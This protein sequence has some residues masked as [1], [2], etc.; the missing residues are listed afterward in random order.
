[1]SNTK[2]IST[3]LLGGLAVFGVIKGVS[4]YNRVKTAVD[5][6]Q[7]NFAFVR[8]QGLIGQGITRFT[9]PILQVIFQIQIQN[10]SDFDIR[11]TRVVATIQ[12]QAANSKE[13]T[14]IA[15]ANHPFEINVKQGKSF[16]HDLPVNFQGLSTLKSLA[17]LSTN[18]YRVLVS[19][20]V[21]NNTLVYT[22]NLPLQQYL[23]SSID[24]LKAGLNLKGLQ[25]NTLQLAG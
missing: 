6:I 20:R 19:Y 4:Y 11:A 7:F 25:Q 22:K 8:V 23:K 3:I 9:N 18:K 12:Q 1:M 24:S 17:N 5:N 14:N 2:T 15:Q 16:S 10:L 21:N 13:W